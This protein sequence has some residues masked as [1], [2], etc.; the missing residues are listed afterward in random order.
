MVELRLRLG[1][2]GLGDAPGLDRRGGPALR[3]A[4]RARGG[5]DLG[6]SGGGLAFGPV[7]LGHGRLGA[8]DRLLARLL[9]LLPRPRVLG[10]RARRTLELGRQ[11]R[12][13][14][15]GLGVLRLDLGDARRRRRVGVARVGELALEAL[16]LAPGGRRLVALLRRSAAPRRRRRREA[17]GAEG[18]RRLLALDATV[19]DAVAELRVGGRGPERLGNQLE[20]AL[21]HRTAGVAGAGAGD[22]D[23]RRRRLTIPV[24]GGSPANRVGVLALE[25]PPLRLLE[26]PTGLDELLDLAG[27][28]ERRPVDQPGGRRRPSQLRDPVGLVAIAGRAE[29]AG[30]RVAPRDE[31]VGMLAVELV[32]L[33]VGG[34]RAWRG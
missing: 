23:E 26:P 11:R 13:V 29:L 27:G 2:P 16:Q 20:R 25:R 18:G 1:R 14:L 28:G 24:R 22:L 32:E 5:L 7:A 31:A 10:G 33:V 9:G 30:E 8:R 19:E 34:D 17:E 15:D 12:G 4:S 21:A 3:V 6:A